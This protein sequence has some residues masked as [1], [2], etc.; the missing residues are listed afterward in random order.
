MIRRGFVVS[1]RVS[2]LATV[3]TLGIGIAFAIAQVAGVTPFAFDAGSYWSATPGDLY[4]GWENRPDGR[5]PFLYS[6]AFADALI[7]LRILPDRVFTGL[8]QLGLF[9]ALAAVARGWSLVFVLAALPSLLFNVLEPLDMVIRDI[10]HGNVQVFL[11]AIAVLGLRFPA[12]WA[13][14]L[15]SKVTPG[16]GLVWFLA[17]REWRN[18]A[19]A[20]GLTGAIALASFLYRPGDWFD[21]F[22]FLRESTSY[23]FPLWVVPVPLPVR[24]L[25]SAAVVWWG[26][27]TDRPWVVPIAVGWAIPM[28]YLTMIATMVFAI[29][30]LASHERRAREP[31]AAWRPR[32]EASSAD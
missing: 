19:I 9:A 11:G 13:F 23:Q 12:L 7:P 27:R 15:L 29:P 5:A 1:P 22:A 24:L 20:V 30:V 31:Q 26:G 6:P 17:R 3:A 18:L 16:V 10:A 4:H 32:R 2:N 28:P 25:M 21:W 14:A 8:W